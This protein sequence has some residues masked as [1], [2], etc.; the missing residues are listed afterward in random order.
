MKRNAKYTDQ[1]LEIDFLPITPADAG[2]V[3]DIYEQYLNGG[4]YMRRHVEEG[5]LA[6]G[7]VGCKAVCEGEIIGVVSARRGI[8]MTYPHPEMEECLRKLFPAR[9]FYSLEAMVVLPQFRRHNIMHTLGRHLLPGLYANGCELFFTELW[10]YPDGD[11]PADWEVSSW[12]ECV[13]EED[14][15]MFY[16]HLA[17]HGMSC[18]LCGE[19]C[20]CGARIK[21]LDMTKKELS[22]RNGD[23]IVL[24]HQKTPPKNF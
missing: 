7:Y 23:P 18:P 10:I 8:D 5:I 21:I 16:A 24:R 4:E 13:Y 6:Q 22:L 12:G 15:P 3:A 17:D 1:G 9:R 2:S 11:I 20:V 19:N 14:V